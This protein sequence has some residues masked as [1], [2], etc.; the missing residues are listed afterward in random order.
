[1]IQIDDVIRIRFPLHRLNTSKWY[2]PWD[3]VYSPN[4]P[5]RT[6]STSDE[7]MFSDQSGTPE[8]RVLLRT[9]APCDERGPM[10]PEVHDPAWQS[11]VGKSYVQR[12]VASRDPLN[13]WCMTWSDSLPRLSHIAQCTS[14]DPTWCLITGGSRR[15]L[16]VFKPNKLIRKRTDA[17]CSSF[18]L[19]VFLGLSNPQGQRQTSILSILYDNLRK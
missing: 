19:R 16:A 4:T 7:G 3:V 18:H 11:V 12:H 5:R 14:F 2:A 9:R 6:G 15:L 8:V 17:N 10:E 13:P 1:M